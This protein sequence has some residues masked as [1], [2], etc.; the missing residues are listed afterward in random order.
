MSQL[1]I[2]KVLTSPLFGIW[3]WTEE[4]YKEP[5]QFQLDGATSR[6]Y[7]EAP[8]RFRDD[9]PLRN[10]QIVMD[11]KFELIFDG[12][13][14]DY[15]TA[16]QSQG[17]KATKFANRIYDYFVETL[18]RLEGVLRVSG[19]VRN[20]TSFGIPSFHSFYSYGWRE[21]ITW[22]VDDQDPQVFRPS[23][24]MPRG[25]IPLFKNPQLVTSDKWKQMQRDINSNRLPS[26]DI[27]ELHRLAGR[28]SPKEKRIPIV[29]A[30]ILIESKLKAYAEAILPEKGF[31]KSKIKDLRDE[32]TF[33]SILNLVLPLTLN[34]TDL[35]RINK[36]RP[37]I[38]RIRKLRNDI[39]HNDLSD[40]A[41]R[42][43]EV[44]NGVNAAVDLFEF[45]ENKLKRK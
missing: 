21:E 29:E 35:R 3:K 9:E 4:D 20:L 24:K 42:E 18:S 6:I 33:N 2:Q 17:A 34:K 38:D 10:L 27:L 13:P 19:K 32:L 45:V 36:W 26:V 41:I 37:Y 16:L 44:L 22:K 40:E 14:K 43:K 8:F 15:I 31:S 11:L 23:L 12:A 39:V 7:V 28:I 25:R 1:I 30:A 5:L